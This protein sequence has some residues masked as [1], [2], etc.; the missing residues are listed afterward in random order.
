MR[1]TVTVIPPPLSRST[2]GCGRKGSSVTSIRCWGELANAVRQNPAVFRHRFFHIFRSAWFF[3]LYKSAHQMTI[4]HRHVL[5]AAVMPNGAFVFYLRRACPEFSAV[6]FRLSVLLR[7][8]RNN[9]LHHI[10]RGKA[11]SPAGSGHGLKRSHHYLFHAVL[12]QKSGFKETTNPAIVQF[13][14]RNEAF[15]PRFFC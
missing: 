12:V 4:E 3:G 8:Y 1:P 2:R 7:K 15:Q 11:R 14:W 5:H 9:V 13:D 10:H 6:R